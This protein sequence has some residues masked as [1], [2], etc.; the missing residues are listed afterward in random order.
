[1]S[2]RRPPERAG[3]LQEIGKPRPH[4]IKEFVEPGDMFRLGDANAIGSVHALPNGA[5]VH[6]EVSRKMSM[7]CLAMIP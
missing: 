4:L 1:M 2:M 3:L 5:R 7:L 6:V